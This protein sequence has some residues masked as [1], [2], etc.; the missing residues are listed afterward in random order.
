MTF[1]AWRLC[2]S[3]IRNYLSA[4]CNHLKDLGC[5]PIDY[6]SHKI[7]K[8]LTGIR[9]IK[10]D[11]ARQAARLL[12]AG[13]LCLFVMLQPMLGHMAVHAAMLLSFRGLLRKACV[14]LSDSAFAGRDVSFH[15]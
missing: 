9:R 10:G 3:S 5:A 4:L 1:L 8:C 15:P 2:Y 7:K 14:T 11:V 12:L 6:T 13:L